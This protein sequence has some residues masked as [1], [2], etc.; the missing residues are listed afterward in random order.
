L[1]D[2]LLNSLVISLFCT[3]LWAISQDGYIFYFLRKPFENLDGWKLFIAKPLILCLPC[4]SSVH[5]L[6]IYYYLHGLSWN[7][8]LCCICAAAFNKLFLL[9]IEKLQYDNR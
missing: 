1:L 6:W 8:I 4:M 7:M 9:T 5:G 2:I 3:G